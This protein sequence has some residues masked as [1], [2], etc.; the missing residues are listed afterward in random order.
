MGRD[1]KR[2][3][4]LERDTSP[5]TRTPSAG[6]KPATRIAAGEQNLA[7][8]HEL[9]TGA[10]PELSGSIPSLRKCFTTGHGLLVDGWCD[11]AREWRDVAKSARW[12]A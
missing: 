5:A 1:G 3:E 4:T 6:A 11:S 10:C 8:G 7:K 2:R 12:R 9:G